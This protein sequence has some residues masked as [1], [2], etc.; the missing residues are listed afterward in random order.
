[1]TLLVVGEHLYGIVVLVFPI[2][3]LRVRRTEKQE[4]E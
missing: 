4:V 2:D 3:E 1:M